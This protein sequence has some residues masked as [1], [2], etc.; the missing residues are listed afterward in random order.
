M[1]IRSIAFRFALMLG[2]GTAAAHADTYVVT[3]FDDSAVIS[4]TARDCSLGSAM[5]A[6]NAHPGHDTI[7]LSSGEYALTLPPYLVIP[8]GALT[9]SEGVTVQ[10]LGSK[11]T[12]IRQYAHYR[13][14][15]VLSTQLALSGLTLLD[16]QASETQY[17]DNAGG[18][19]F[20]DNGDLIL[21]DVVV[22]NC[23]ATYRGGGLFMFNGSLTLDASVIELNRAP[24]GGAIAMGGLDPLVTLR[25]HGRLYRNQ[26][27]EGGAV[28]SR[29]GSFNADGAIVSPAAVVMSSDSLVDGNHATYGGAFACESG[30]GLSVSLAS[31]ELG[32]PGALAHVSSNTIAD[33]DGKGGAFFSEGTLRLTR[34]LLSNNNAG[35]G[36][37]VYFRRALLDTSQCPVTYVTDSLLTGNIANNDGGAIWGGKGVA[38]ING[39]SFHDNHASDGRGGAVYY[40]SGDQLS[41]ASCDLAVVFLTNASI[42]ENTAVHGAGVAL[43]NDG[44]LM[45]YAQL[46]TRYST[47]LGNHSTSFDGASDVRIENKLVSDGSGGLAWTG[48][49]TTTGS[50]IYTGGCDYSA[51]PDLLSYGANFD[52][53]AGGCVLAASGDHVGVPLT[54]LALAHGYYGGP[55]SVVGITSSRS[56][57]IDASHT[58]CPNDDARGALRDPRVCDSGAFEFGAGIL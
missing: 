1:S 28:H 41:P 48:N 26:A 58:Y 7:K 17:P 25:N 31:D 6:A 44:G 22:A 13:V 16:G 47:W 54:T 18:C 50:S 56:P 23:T 11:Y 3:R 34:V 20:S 40:Q 19:L 14:F 8:G 30:K 45:G 46:S 4:C 9:V 43:G 52:T 10:G 36:G 5:V 39:A 32:V 42:S 53:T 37:A 12:T 24:L 21:T 57:A 15:T 49:G 27:E 33:V 29:A 55:F 2:I 51:V 35:S 38:F